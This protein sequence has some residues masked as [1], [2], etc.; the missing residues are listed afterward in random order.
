MPGRL[1]G[2]MYSSIKY[3]NCN[4]AMKYMSAAKSFQLLFLPP[5]ACVEKL[6]SLASKL[7]S[8][9]CIWML[10]VTVP[11]SPPP[12]WW[13]WIRCFD[14]WLPLPPRPSQACLSL[15]HYPFASI[16]REAPFLT[17]RGPVLRWYYLD[18]C[19]LQKNLLL[20]ISWKFWP[21]N[22]VS[23][24]LRIFIILIHTIY[25]SFLVHHCTI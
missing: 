25:L 19:L 1:Q 20:W 11:G 10:P 21:N 23:F 22:A 18:K 8:S 7:K 5:K 9:V 2:W 15:P 12:F 6:W 16:G 3:H 14:N 17:E 13:K 24:F 4:N